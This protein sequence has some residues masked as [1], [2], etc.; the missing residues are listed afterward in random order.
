MVESSR[1]K[2]FKFRVSTIRK[3]KARHRKVAGFVLE[4]SQLESCSMRRRHNNPK[5]DPYFS[6]HGT[7]QCTGCRLY[8]YGLGS[9]RDQC[10]CGRAA[11]NRCVGCNE[12][13]WDKQGVKV[14]WGASV[15]ELC[16]ECAAKVP[17]T[18][19]VEVAE[20]PIREHGL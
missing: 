8:S 5:R 6:H 2:T 9:H 13:L 20:Y 12:K 4:L 1:V 10:L 18:A 3:H 14:H 11:R 19:L 7:Y 17:P 16:K 15:K